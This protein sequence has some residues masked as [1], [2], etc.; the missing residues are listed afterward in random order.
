MSD[1]SPANPPAP[2]LAARLRGF[3]A[4]P[5]PGPIAIVLGVTAGFALLAPGSPPTGLDWVALLG[6]MFGGQLAI[7]AVN[8]IVDAADDAV[9]KPAKPIPSGLVSVRAAQIL[10]G[11]GLVGM[12]VGSAALGAAS[13]ALCTTGTVAGLAYDLWFKRSAFSWFPYLVALPLIPIWVWTALDAFDPAL[14]ALY[15]L[16]AGATLAVHLAQALPDVAA[17]R[18]TG[19]ESLTTRLGQRRALALCLAALCVSSLLALLAADA[20]GASFGVLGPAAAFAVG[21]VLLDGLLY[22]RAPDLGVRACFPCVAVGTAVLGL[23]WVLALG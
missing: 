15:P 6:A 22:L 17:D 21:L 20:I 13:L 14:L 23:G 10:T 7:G 16:G 9:A 5:H 3:V 18:S 19:I 4:L 1:P 12:V 2:R 8:E 11:I